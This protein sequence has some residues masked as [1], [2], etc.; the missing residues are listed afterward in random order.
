MK[1]YLLSYLGA[2]AAAV[3]VS[4]VMLLIALMNWLFTDSPAWFEALTV[5]LIGLTV[6]GLGELFGS[7]PKA[8]NVEKPWCGFLI[9]LPVMAVLG[10]VPAMTESILYAVSLPGMMLGGMVHSMLELRYNWD[11]WCYGIGNVMIPCLF[12]LGWHWGRTA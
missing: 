9:L 5:V 7:R 4:L 8:K 10:L 2:Y 6:L 11:Y 12:H 3:A 1:R